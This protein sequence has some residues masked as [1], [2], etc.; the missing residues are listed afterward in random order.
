MQSLLNVFSP[1]NKKEHQEFRYNLL[2]SIKKKGFSHYLHQLKTIQ[3]RIITTEKNN[4]MENFLN[5][6]YWIP[7][8]DK[9]T[10]WW[11][12]QEEFKW[13]SDKYNRAFVKSPTVFFSKQMLSS[14]SI[15]KLLGNVSYLTP[16][17]IVFITELITQYYHGN[18]R[19]WPVTMNIEMS[20]LLYSKENNYFKKENFIKQDLMKL[21][22]YLLSGSGPF[23]LKILQQVANNA[24][25]IKNSDINWSELTEN[26]FDAV[27]PLTKEEFLFVKEN[28]SKTPFIS[29]LNNKTIGSASLAETHFA[30]DAFGGDSIVKLI[31]PMYIIYFLCEC[32]FL[33]VDLWKQIGDKIRTSVVPQKKQDLLIKQ[34]RQLLLYLVRD[35]SYEFDYEKESIYT[36]IGYDT[37]NQPSLNVFSSQ[38]IQFAVDPY[39]IIVQTK[40]GD[41]SLK[42]LLTY[43]KS[44]QFNRAYPEDG[45]KLIKTVARL[46]YHSL[47]NLFKIWVK[48]VFWGKNHF[49]HADLHSGNIRTL[50]FDKLVKLVSLSDKKKQTAPI[51]VIDY[52]SAGI[53]KKNVRCRLLT[54]LLQSSNLVAMPLPNNIEEEEVEVDTEI[55]REILPFYGKHPPKGLSV[56]L[57][58]KKVLENHRKNVKESKIFVR[59]VYKLC[60]IE[61]HDDIDA[62]SKYIL[63]YKKP[64]FFSNLFLNL[65]RFG[66]EIGKCT[67]NQM[68]N[69]GRG[70]AYLN[71][72]I[73]LL[74][75]QCDPKDVEMFFI[76]T[77][78]KKE[79][80]LHP[81][82]LFN[83]KTGKEIC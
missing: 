41:T 23:M 5:D 40:V 2:T 61:A 12:Q 27:P 79:L 52:G 43:W 56:A 30:K 66:G 60:E 53:L 37:Y 24:D 57:N 14:S 82:Q 69:F 16:Q 77:I 59:R 28:L 63:K 83:L 42:S 76:N 58:N 33:L 78:I 22:M 17:Q 9:K 35:Y 55:T 29:H 49:F 20:Y 4:R 13:A 15:D 7:L 36:S 8:F 50:E 71:D 38:L 74:Y 70:I 3:T 44:E 11:E 6:D 39:P 73:Q 19:L 54:A 68:I 21:L 10:S 32:D 26:I 18:K 47:C 1:F 67:S 72:T 81:V 51:F 48:N 31:R 64:L 65:I 25:D 46:L 80:L 62:I 75:K 45:K 34:T